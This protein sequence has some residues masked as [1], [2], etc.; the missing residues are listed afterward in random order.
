MQHSD[1]DQ[2]QTHRNGFN[3]RDFLRASALSSVFL[4]SGALAG[5]ASSGAPARNGQPPAAAALGDVEGSAK[6]VI[7]LVSDGMSM[8]AFTAADH[9]LRRREDRR[10]NWARLYEEERVDHRGLMDMASRDSIVT[11]SAAAASSWGC[12]H[13]IN[14]G[15]VNQDPEGNDLRTI[16]EIFRDAG[17]STGLVSTARVTHATPAG[18]AAN[19]PERGMEDEIAAQY[20]E[21]GYDLI[22]G[23]GS[24]HFDPEEREDGRDLFAAFSE[25]DYH[26]IRLREELLGLSRDARP[27]LGTF[28]DTHVP[29]TIDHVNTPRYQREVPTLAEMTEVA[30]E[31]L[32]ENED[33]F[34]LQVEGGRV[35]HAAHSNDT[36]GLVF[37]QIAFDDAIGVVLEFV[38]GRD[39]TLV[40]ITTDHGNANPGLNGIGAGYRDSNE[41]FD[42]IGEMQYSNNWVLDGLDEESSV[43]EIQERVE[44][45]WR[46]GIRQDEAETLQASLRGEFEAVYRARSAPSAVLSAIQA[47]YTAVNWVGS[48]HTAD[49]VELAGLGPGSEALPGFVRNTDLFELMVHVAGVQTYAAG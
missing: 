18:F 39:D 5:C 4:G 3:R 41:M 31:R 17:K 22:L 9:M 42:R 16:C 48:M 11:D 25:E 24:R 36:A 46:F 44:E 27:V 37:D 32:S 23:G 29:Y 12:G 38:E 49:Y 14:N 26:V 45:A 47:N 30:L 35:D 33:G 1:D 6:N 8:G 13:R 20:L 7:F 15:A 2:S 21:R 19:V 40:L 10:A 28:F 34:I 43:R